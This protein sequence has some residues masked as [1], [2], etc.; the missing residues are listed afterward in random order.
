MT[1]LSYFRLEIAGDPEQFAALEGGARGR[2]SRDRRL[3][4]KD[5]D[6]EGVAGQVGTDCG[7]TWKRRPECG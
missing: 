3:R 4:V 1:D 6:I 5:D 7:W 2:E